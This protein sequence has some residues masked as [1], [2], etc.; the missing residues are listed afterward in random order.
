MKCP[1]QTRVIHKPEDIEGYV[2]HFAMDVTE[3]GNCLKEE[4]PFY[5]YRINPDASR[6]EYCYKAESEIRN[7]NTPV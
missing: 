3:F 6:T 7:E 2:K 5:H 1:Y 4:C